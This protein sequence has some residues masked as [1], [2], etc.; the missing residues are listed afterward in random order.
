MTFCF[1]RRPCLLGTLR[2][3]QKKA[4]ETGSSLH[5]GPLGNLKGAHFTRELERQ[6][7]GSGDRMSLSMG[8]L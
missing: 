8:A 5:R 2:D 3:M 4:L 1:T 6:M 7:E